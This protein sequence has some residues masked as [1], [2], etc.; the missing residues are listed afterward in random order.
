MD[1]RKENYLIGLL[2]PFSITNK[3]AY[4]SV[5]KSVAIGNVSC[6]TSLVRAPTSKWYYTFYCIKMLIQLMFA[7]SEETRN[8]HSCSHN[9]PPYQTS[10]S[11]LNRGQARCEVVEVLGCGRRFWSEK[12]LIFYIYINS[13]RNCNQVMLSIKNWASR[14]WVDKKGDFGFKLGTGSRVLYF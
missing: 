10:N 5:S 9:K 1:C 2:N 12:I 13:I 3:R 14:G 11:C 4:G 6:G 8:T 7:Y